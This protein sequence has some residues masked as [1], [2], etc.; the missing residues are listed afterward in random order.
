MAN[1]I[2]AARND[3]EV[4]CNLHVKYNEYIRKYQQKTPVGHVVYGAVFGLAYVARFNYLRGLNKKI[5]RKHKEFAF[6]NS[7]LWKLASGTGTSRVA[8]AEIV[9]MMEYLSK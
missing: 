1:T 3:F 2:A 5:L 4:G 6:T 9:E 8:L 7:C